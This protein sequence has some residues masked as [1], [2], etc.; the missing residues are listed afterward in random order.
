M[1]YIKKGLKVLTV[2]CPDLGCYHQY[3]KMNIVK[4]V[5]RYLKMFWNIYKKAKIKNFYLRI[6]DIEE[7]RIEELYKVQRT[8]KNKTKGKLSIAPI[9]VTAGFMAAGVTFILLNIKRSRK[10]IKDGLNKLIKPCDDR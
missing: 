5:M 10:A 1:F 2:Y 8:I 4:G 9:I 3:S 6:R 7:D